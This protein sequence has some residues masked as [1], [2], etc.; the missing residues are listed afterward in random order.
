[1]TST[2]VPA[3][4]PRACA[5]ASRPRGGPPGWAAV[6]LGGGI[7]VAFLVAFRGSGAFSDEGSVCAI[8]QEILNGRLPY[9][10]YF[11]EKAPLQYLWTALVMWLS[12]DGIPGARIASTITLGSTLGLTLGRVASRTGSWSL[13]VLWAVV[14][15]LAGLITGVYN[16]TAE[17]TLALLWVGSAVLLLDGSSGPSGWRWL[18]VGC[19]E[20]LACGA[21]QTAIVPAGVLLFAAGARACRLRYLAGLGIGLVAWGSVVWRLGIAAETLDA[22]VLFH[23]GNPE[24]GSYFRGLGDG[25]YPALSLWLLVLLYGAV[26]ARARRERAWVLAWAVSAALPFFGRMDAFRLWPSVILMLTYLASRLGPAGGVRTLVPLLVVATVG[27]RGLSPPRDFARLDEI[28]SRV[29]KYVAVGESIW[30]GPFDPNVYCVTKRRSASRYYFILPWVAKPGVREALL[31]DIERNRPT[32]ILDLSS[33]TE[34]T[35]ELLPGLEA[36]LAARYVLAE[37][38]GDARYFVLREA[39]ATG[40]L[41]P[42]PGREPGARAASWRRGG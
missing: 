39:H 5:P 21:R 26:L 27:L 36:L 28:R 1:V 18:A 32:L 41:E 33:A 13:T 8:A 6:G 24:I 3:T 14:I 12:T 15:A 35:R 11:N 17:S 22:T 10:D 7:A 16:N 30:V 38:G 2:V 34:S 29:D 19:L 37:A 4:R 20:G 40:T 23:R 42:G 9:R 25:D 31:S